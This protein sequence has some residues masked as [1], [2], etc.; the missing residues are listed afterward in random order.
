MKNIL[1]KIITVVLRLEAK[2][3]VKKYNPH[4]IGVTGSVGKTSAKE[5]IYAT[6]ANRAL[7]ARR[8]GKSYKSYNSEIGVPLALIGAETAW[9]SP[10]GWLRII[11]QGARLILWRDKDFPEVMVLEMGVDRPGDISRLEEIVRPHVAVM[12]AIGE[13]PVHVE[14]FA[15]PEEVAKEKSK[16]LRHLGID[17]FA[18]LN[19]D[20]ATVYNMHDKTRSKVLTF[21][22]G[23]R[24]NICASNYQIMYEK[25]E[26][27]SDM[28]LGIS[29]KVDHNGHTVP[30]RLYGVF[31][32]QQVYAALAAVGVGIAE[33]MNVVEISE[34]LSKYVP[35]PGRLKLI[36]GIKHT[37]LLDDTYNSSPQALHA[38]LDTLAETP[39]KRR[40]A[41]LGDMLE[42]GKYTIEAHQAIGR[43]VY[44]VA[45]VLF[46]VG[47]RAKFIAQEA[48]ELG[49]S[50]TH[51]FEFSDSREAGPVLQNFMKEGDLV[52]IKGSQSTRMERVVEEVMAHPENAASLLVRQDAYWKK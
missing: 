10:L 17:D 9:S 3:I 30:V 8:V 27:G 16:I 2:L 26:D 15:G 31:G 41:V 29:F 28:P 7:V 1:K 5:A 24:A 34:A 14:F 49:M 48:R 13:V 52:L 50:H 36:E 39:A 44:K 18:I 43:H 23:E 12:T 35:A 32:K 25:G 4:V 45:D 20:D 6:L 47:P 42:L 11:L 21:G 33:G 22:F 46:A 19:F 37:W 38:A 51:I 40:I